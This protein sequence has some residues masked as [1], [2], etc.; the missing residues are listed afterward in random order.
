MEEL[1]DAPLGNSIVWVFGYNCEIDWIGS[2]LI[3]TSLFENLTNLR[4]SD[5]RHREKIVNAFVRSLR[6]FAGNYPIGENG[7]G[8]VALKDAITLVVQPRGKGNRPRDDTVRL[9]EKLK[10]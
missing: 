7:N 4:E 3:D 2:M 1:M 8:K 9:I 10:W 5:L 6:K